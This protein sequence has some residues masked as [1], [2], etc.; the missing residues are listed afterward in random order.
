MK[1][2]LERLLNLLAALLTADR[3]MPADEIRYTVAGYED[4]SDE[5]F[6]RMFERDKDLL[7]DMGIPLELK[8]TD[9]WEVEYG[10]VL[11][12]EEYQLEDPGLTDEE[13]AALWLAAQVVRVGGQPQGP[14]AILKLGGMPFAGGGEPLAADL[15]IGSSELSL[16][17]QAVTDRMVVA[18][19]YR[20]RRRLVRPYGLVHR[21]GHWYLIGAETTDDSKAFRIDRLRNLQTVS[22]AGAFQRPSGFKAA[23][24]LPE[25]PWEAGEDD[26]VCEVLFDSD[27][28]WWAERQLPAGA[29]K[30]PNPD[31]SITATL[32][33]ANE[34]ALIGWIL[35]FEDK[36]EILSPDRLRAGL[37]RRVGHE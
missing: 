31:G 36:A 35:A 2:V 11:P 18:F 10:Y 20:D 23:Q 30:V 19:D 22:E 8:P 24:A 14:E 27:V 21:R 32:T 3:P 29:Q 37:L 7:R 13:R 6:H 12:R 25:A 28:A 4:K 17:F 9:V 5:A 16:A 15:G 34:D 1:N 26:L 33:V